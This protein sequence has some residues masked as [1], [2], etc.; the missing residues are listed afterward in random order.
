MGNNGGA[1][2]W[3]GVREEAGCWRGKRGG[4]PRGGGATA[5]PTSSTRSAWGLGA[6]CLEIQ[7]GGG[8]MPLP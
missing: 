7:N 4:E 2:F 3:L 1:A 8:E 5:H 6:F